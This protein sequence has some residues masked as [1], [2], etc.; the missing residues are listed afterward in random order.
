M[1]YK[2][3]GGRGRGRG[4]KQHG[5]GGEHHEERRHCV[6]GD[7]S[8]LL[9]FKTSKEHGSTDVHN[10]PLQI[11][12]DSHMHTA[13][14]VCVYINTMPN[15]MYANIKDYFSKQKNIQAQK[16]NTHIHTHRNIYIRGI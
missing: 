13:K 10:R 14:H 15:V 2:E 8:A 12:P 5:G 11:K 3:V 7:Y 16:R 9:C 4:G 6:A 1:D